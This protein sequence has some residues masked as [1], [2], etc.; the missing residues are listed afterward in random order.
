MNKIEFE[1]ILNVCCS[2]L[3][4]EA[5][6]VSFKSASQFENRVREVLGDLTK[7]ETSFSVDFN[8]HPQAFPDIAMGE[9]GVEVKFT[10]NDTWRS[11]ANSVL[12]T[13]RIE[14]VKHIYIVFGKMGGVPEVAWGE[15]EQSVIH[16]RTSHVP[17]FEVEVTPNKAAVKT[18][19]FEQMGIKY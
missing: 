14:S 5:R 18:S 3:T 9:Y 15:Y 13:Q 4:E 16:V 8:P 11:V 6:R 7:G 1:N 19:L 10:L 2:Q 17:R 12:E